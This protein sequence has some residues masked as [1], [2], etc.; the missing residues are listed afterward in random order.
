M[1][2]IAGSI[3]HSMDY[4]GLYSLVAR[5]GEM[6][7]NTCMDL[8]HPLP[9]VL[10]LFETNSCCGF[11]Q[12]PLI[13]CFQ[14]LSIP[15]EPPTSYRL[16]TENFPIHPTLTSNIHASIMHVTCRSPNPACM[17]CIFGSRQ[18]PV[19]DELS[20]FFTRKKTCSWFGPVEWHCWNPLLAIACCFRAGLLTSKQ[21]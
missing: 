3:P 16:H 5:D 18:P 1:S 21:G 4:I 14:N 7:V 9:L 13:L 15:S 12:L 8:T 11:S 10:L 6:P 2:E 20:Q 19:L 17:S